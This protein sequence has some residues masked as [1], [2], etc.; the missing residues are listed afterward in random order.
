MTKNY[1]KKDGTLALEDGSNLYDGESIYSYVPGEFKVWDI[2]TF[3]KVD[4]LLPRIMLAEL[5]F[6]KG[7]SGFIRR[8]PRK[9]ETFPY[10]IYPRAELRLKGE[11]HD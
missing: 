6:R 9:G 5:F 7:N 10:L 11:P 8:L 2:L 4:D 1:Y 3:V